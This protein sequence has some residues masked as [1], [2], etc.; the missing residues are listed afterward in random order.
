M[1]YKIVESDCLY[2]VGKAITISK[3][4]YQNEEIILE[5]WNS[6]F[7]QSNSKILQ[8]LMADDCVKGVTYNIK[9]K[10]DR[11]SYL[12]GVSSSEPI[13]IK[14]MDTIVIPSQK[15][16]V[17]EQSGDEVSSIKSFKKRVITEWLPT[18]S[19]SII[20]NV[21]IEVYFPR[22]IDNKGCR[23]EYWISIDRSI[24]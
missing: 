8:G 9:P 15:Y 16:V 7:T 23:F 17:F 13:R 19:L 18:T 10:L 20:P 12:V 6:F 2:F 24:Q 3:K 21:E 14:N 4:D 5:L 1:K 11:I 22:R